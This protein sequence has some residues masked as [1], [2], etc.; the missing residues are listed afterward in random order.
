MKRR[1]QRIS[2]K[3]KAHKGKARRRTLRNKQHRKLR[4]RPQRGGVF[5]GKGISGQVFRP[6]PCNL[7]VIPEVAA[8]PEGFVGKLMTNSRALKEIATVQRIQ[9]ELRNPAAAAVVVPGRPFPPIDEQYFYTD[10]LGWALPDPTNEDIIAK[11]AEEGPDVS[12]ADFIVGKRVLIYRN[13]GQ[14]L[15]DYFNSTLFPR[16]PG[17]TPEHM[18]T[19]FYNFL[20]NLSGLFLGGRVLEEKGIIHTDIKQ[21]NLAITVTVAPAV[22]LLRYIDFGSGTLIGDVNEDEF[23]F[24]DN[25]VLNHKPWPLECCITL[26]PNGLLNLLGNC[27]VAGTNFNSTLRS[28]FRRGKRRL[29][30][31]FLGYDLT[32]AATFRASHAQAV[33]RKTIL[34]AY[35]VARQQGGPIDP[36]LVAG[37]QQALDIYSDLQFRVCEAMKDS[38]L[39]VINEVITHRDGGGAGNYTFYN[40]FDE[41]TTLRPEYQA[42]GVH[43]PNVDAILPTLVLDGDGF[44]KF[45]FE[46]LEDYDDYQDDENSGNEEREQKKNLLYDLE[47][48][49]RTILVRKLDVFSIGIELFEIIAF[50]LGDSATQNPPGAR[51]VVSPPLFNQAL[52]VLRVC[53]Q[54]IDPNFRSRISFLGHNQA[55]QQ[56]SQTS[57][58]QVPIPAGY[59]PAAQAAAAE[60][61]GLLMG[62]GGAGGA[63]AMNE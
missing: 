17:R 33:G 3:G 13:A 35:E 18:N 51:W 58:F 14:T 56:L 37:R 53:Q 2:R 20:H 27:R 22:G 45:N 59:V 32:S 48:N 10:Y 24:P 25:R 23:L 50:I 21:D 15:L 30:L 26:V 16:G 38:I 12:A 6:P 39:S 7:A 31:D 4:L 34:A 62:L 57:V 55:E 19:Q 29:L 36:L 11:A 5:L 8:N 43:W 63:A 52:E 49:M 54:M 41:F 61:A 1:A 47:E 28:L 42:A 46:K 9:E 44:I 40:L 60:A